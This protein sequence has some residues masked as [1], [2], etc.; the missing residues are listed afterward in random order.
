MGDEIM[1]TAPEIMFKGINRS[2]YTDKLITRGI[3]KLEQ[4]C[5][6]IVST[7]VMVEQIQTR[8]RTDNPY[9]V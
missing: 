7:R 8:H 9:A 6:Y 3:A 2:I 4:V 5:N 1:E